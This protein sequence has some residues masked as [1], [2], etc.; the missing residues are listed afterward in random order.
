MVVKGPCNLTNQQAA[1]A[2]KNVL[3]EL[4]EKY[5]EYLKY[6]EMTPRPTTKI[7]M[8][9]NDVCLTRI[10]C[11]KNVDSV[12]ILNGDFIVE[13]DETTQEVGSFIDVPW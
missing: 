10:Q 8:V 7:F 1:I 3:K 6:C 11:A 4:A 12:N 9:V 5:P 2:W 13:V